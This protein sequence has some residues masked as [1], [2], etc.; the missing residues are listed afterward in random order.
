MTRDTRDPIYSSKGQTL[1]GEENI[2]ASHS[3]CVLHQ[4]AI[5]V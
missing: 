2:L 3:L 4:L 1:A 5:S